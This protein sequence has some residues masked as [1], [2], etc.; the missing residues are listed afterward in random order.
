MYTWVF[1]PGFA[2]NKPFDYIHTEGRRFGFMFWR[3]VLPEGDI[4][5][6]TTTVVTLKDLAAAL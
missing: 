2:F 4:V 3:F 5:S 6:P 1:R